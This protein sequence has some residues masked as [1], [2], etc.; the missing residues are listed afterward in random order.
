MKRKQETAPVII[1]PLQGRFDEMVDAVLGKTGG[2]EKAVVRK[3][4]EVETWAVPLQDIYDNATIRLDASHY[5][6]ETAVALQE[7][8][9]SKS[10]LNPLSELADVRLPGQFVRIWAEEKTYGL[11][12]VNA[13]D[14]MSLTG[15]GDFSGK[16]RYLSK[17]TDVDMKEL[18]IHKGWLL[19]TCSG[20][21]GRVFY[22]PKRLDG[23][24]ATHDLIRI[25]PKPG[26]P[27][28][29][30]HAYLSSPVAQKQITGHTHGGQIDHVTH[31]QIGEVLV[32][33][34]PKNT[35]AELHERTM[36]A[37]EKREEAIATLSEIANDTQRLI[38]K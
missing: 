1:D 27:V 9:K 38:K 13:T 14:L 30:L 15:I 20:T 28:G 16:S 37:L 2:T 34:L 18:I 19:I 17:E 32:P 22:V 4:P 12:Y 7:L 31:H 33:I 8:Q 10:S 6:R 24:V 29:F 35:M 36:Q 21:I 26:I 11:P 25:I 3:V 5:N 23:W